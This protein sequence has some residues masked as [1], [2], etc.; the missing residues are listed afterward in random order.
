MLEKTMLTMLTQVYTSIKWGQIIMIGFCS[1]RIYHTQFG[2]KS[3]TEEP[4]WN[5]AF[6]NPRCSLI[7]TQYL[8]HDLPLSHSYK[9]AISG[10]VRIY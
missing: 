3:Q 2:I 7:R 10:E 9:R 8:L 1:P 4:R 6:L 5:S